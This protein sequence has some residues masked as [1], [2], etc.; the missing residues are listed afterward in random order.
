MTED[1]PYTFNIDSDIADEVVAAWLLRHIGF[2]EDRI[3]QGTT[4]SEDWIEADKD[5]KAFRHVLYYMTG[6]FSYAD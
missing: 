4:D 5:L 1:E 6:D 2:A 3:N